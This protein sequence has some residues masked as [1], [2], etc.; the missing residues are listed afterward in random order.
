MASCTT[1]I[2]VEDNG[3]GRPVQPFTHL[4]SQSL[5]WSVNYSSGQPVT[6]LVSQSL[7]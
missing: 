5:I 4:V 6:D 3:L 7:I 2:A 1:W